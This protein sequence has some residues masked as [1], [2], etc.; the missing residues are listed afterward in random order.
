YVKNPNYFKP[1]L[2]Y[3]DGLKIYIIREPPAQRAAFVAQRVNMTTPTIGMPT[4]SIY[5]H[6][7]KR[8]PDGK[9]S[10][11]DFPLVRLFWFNLKADKPWNDLRVRRAI[12]LALDREQLIIAGVGDKEWGRIG[13]VFPPGSPYALPSEEMAAIQGW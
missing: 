12:N 5:D 6:H 2:P 3:L 11:Q 8:V 4:Q 1:G 7:Q 10:I 13:G 9:Y